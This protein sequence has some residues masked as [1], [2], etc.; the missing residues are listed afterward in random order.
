[1]I[2]SGRVEV[3]VLCAG[4]L[5]D[6]Q[7]EPH[8][9]VP[10]SPTEPVED[11]NM[12]GTVDTS[13]PEMPSEEAPVPKVEEGPKDGEHAEGSLAPVSPADKE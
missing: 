13:A 11:S 2:P 7:L 12:D 4:S 3:P 5:G 9:E 8:C 1:M 6:S 10:A